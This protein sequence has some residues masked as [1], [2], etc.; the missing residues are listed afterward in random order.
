MMKNPHQPPAINP[1]NAVTFDVTQRYL[2]VAYITLDTSLLF[3]K[4]AKPRCLQVMLVW[5]VVPRGL[6]STFWRDL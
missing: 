3:G 2:Y 6:L 1:I 4:S 5:E